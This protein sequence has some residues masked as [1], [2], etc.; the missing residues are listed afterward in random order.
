[1][2]ASGIM[3]IMAAIG[4]IGATA[5]MWGRDASTGDS[6]VSMAMTVGMAGSHPCLGAAI[7][8]AVSMAGAGMAVVAAAT[9]RL[10]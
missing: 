8:A 6:A 10:F 7:A 1:M 9:G 3:A 4:A 2:W 5:M